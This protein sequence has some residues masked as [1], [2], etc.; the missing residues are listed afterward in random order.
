[1]NFFQTVYA[2]VRQVPPGRVISYGQI[3]RIIGNPRMARQVGWA[4]H[5]LRPEDRVPWHR[6]VKQN[7]EILDALNAQGE[8][9]QRTLLEDEGVAFDEQ[10]RVLR[11]YFLSE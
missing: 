11:M 9:W 1:M 6:V 3:A 5:A 7:G 2:I 8:N 10:G 4:M